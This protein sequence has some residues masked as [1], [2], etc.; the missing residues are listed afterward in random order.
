MDE[1]DLTPIV[2]RLAKARKNAGLS[3]SQVAVMMGCVRSNIAN[4]E[5]PRSA[6]SLT[7]FL[8]MCVIYGASPVWVLTGTNPDFNREE[9]ATMLA[10]TKASIEDAVALMELFEMSSSKREAGM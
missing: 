1:I 3:Q 9:A 4:L 6:I 8:Q 7:Q 10:Q 2:E 5:S